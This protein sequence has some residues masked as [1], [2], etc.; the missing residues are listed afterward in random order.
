MIVRIICDGVN[1]SRNPYPSVEWEP[2]PSWGVKIKVFAGLTCFEVSKLCWFKT[3]SSKLRLTLKLTDSVV[4]ILKLRAQLNKVRCKK[5]K[6][7]QYLWL[8]SDNVKLWIL[9]NLSRAELLPCS[10]TQ[11]KSYVHPESWWREYKIQTGC[12]GGCLLPPS[13]QIRHQLSKP[14]WWSTALNLTPARSA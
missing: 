11:G 7:C 14:P 5:D 9:R 3:R 1:P 4:L 2:N 12:E 10:T 13:E 8:V 6:Q